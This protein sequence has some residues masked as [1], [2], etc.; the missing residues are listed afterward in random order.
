MASPEKNICVIIQAT[1]YDVSE[2]RKLVDII[3]RMTTN[4]KTW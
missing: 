3:N 4:C 2:V 1:V